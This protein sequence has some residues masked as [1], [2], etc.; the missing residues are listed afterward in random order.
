MLN[1]LG[2][3]WVDRGTNLEHARKMI[4]RAVNLRPNDGYIID[5]LG[6]VL[7][8]LGDYH[9]ATRELERAIV[10]LPGDPIINDHLGDAYW[11]VDRRQEARFQWRRALMFNPEPE[12][13]TTID[14][15][16]KRGL[17]EPSPPVPTKNG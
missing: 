5:S 14:S 9:G 1:Y 12:L 2:Y 11:R 17:D 8:R 10:L 7:Y 15:K 6:W 16:L 4:E 13:R 3:S